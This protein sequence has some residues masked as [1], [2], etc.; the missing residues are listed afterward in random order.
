MH[1]C[2]QYR[3]IYREA[4]ANLHANNFAV[5]IET[6]GL[7]PGRWRRRQLRA[8]QDLLL[9]IEEETNGA[10]PLEAIRDPYGDGVGYHVQFGAPGP[11]TPVAKSCPGPKRIKQFWDV[12][13]PWMRSNP[14]EEDMLS[15]KDWDREDWEAID[16]H[17]GP[18]I[19]RRVWN[20]PLR[21]PS[22]LVGARKRTARL[23]MYQLMQYGWATR[24]WQEENE[25]EPT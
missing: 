22:Q 15:P 21:V 17:L 9:W 12:L 16:R 24:T 2:E 11:W 19:A 20:E 8:I 13:V 23:I 3:S 4:D 7:G 10:V 5:S 14:R 18:K 1:N 6:A 25:D